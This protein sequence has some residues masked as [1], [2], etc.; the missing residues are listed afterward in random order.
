[1]ERVLIPGLSGSGWPY[2]VYTVTIDGRQYLTWEQDYVW[3]LHEL[4]TDGLPRFEDEHW[5]MIGF[6]DEGFFD[7][8]KLR[9]DGWDAVRDDQFVAVW[10]GSGELLTAT[11]P[12][13]LLACAQQSHGAWS[14]AEEQRRG[15]AA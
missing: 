9:G 8:W 12:D 13:D 4:T 3:G 14:M 1:M 2:E 5:A 10:V 6:T 11:L 7:H 15:G